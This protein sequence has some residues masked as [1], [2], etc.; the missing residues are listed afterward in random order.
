MVRV[1]VP[2]VM[3]EEWL[4]LFPA[5]VEIVRLPALPESGTEVEFL[6]S[7]LYPKQLK[8]IYPQLAGVKV[9]QALLAGVDW[10]LAEVRPGGADSGPVVC[11][12]QGCHNVTTSEWVLMAILAM[13]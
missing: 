13:L 6:I 1:G 2:E 12:A 5:E 11:D 3:G 7:P 9:V 4:H 8:A 10:T